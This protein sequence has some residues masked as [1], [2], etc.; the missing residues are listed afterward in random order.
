MCYKNGIGTSPNERKAIEYLQKA[1]NND[2]KCQNENEIDPNVDSFLKEIMLKNALPWIPF[3]EL[4]NIQNAYTDVAIIVCSAE[5]TYPHKSGVRIRK[6]RLDL[7]TGFADADSHEILLNELN[8]YCI[9]GSKRPTFLQ[10]YGVSRDV[11]TGHYIVVIQDGLVNSLERNLTSVVKMGWNDKLNLLLYIAR[12]LQLIH[13]CNIINCGLYEKAILQ[14]NLTSAYIALSSLLLSVDKAL[15]TKSKLIGSIFYI[16]PE[17]LNHGLFTKASDI[18]SFGIIMWEISSGKSIFDYYREYYEHGIESIQFNFDVC[19]GMRPNI[20]ENMVQSYSD[21]M[22][23][24]WDNDPQKR[25]SISKI[26]KILTNWKNNMAKFYEFESVIYDEPDK[27]E[28]KLYDSESYDIMDIDQDYELSSFNQQNSVN[29][30]SITSSMDSNIQ[31]E[32]STP[33]EWLEKAISEDHINYIEY[34]KFT[35]PVVIGIGGFGKVFK[36]EWKDGELT[37]A[38]KCLKVD[39]SIDEKIIK[40]FIDELKLLRKVSCHPNVIAFYGVTKDNSGNYNMILEYANEGTLREY[41][42]KR[43]LKLQWTDK[44]R[45]AKEIALG[46]LYLHDKNIIHRDLHSKNILVHQ[47]HPKI[48]D[49]GLSKQMNEVSTTSNSIV[50]GILAYI[51]PQCFISKDI[52]AIRDLTS[53][54]LDKS[55]GK[56]QAEDLHPHPL[57]LEI[58]TLLFTYFKEI[59]KSL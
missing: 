4:K 54:V 22:K 33:K 21:L 13:S 24:Y 37:V 42:K 26:L 49:L 57:N 12:D 41:L 51:E 36:C 1:R 15:T 44:L 5:W 55:F 25:P 38:L 2:D 19:N 3:N 32:E 47:R 29:L 17:V 28:Y 8:A 52:N 43:F 6:V 7:L 30:F 10:C 35:D 11:T 27:D 23:R 48:S 45:I 40:D 9:I 31:I 14:N 56:F 59:E 50:H 53:I 34:N 39:T 18:Y 58:Y 16:A 46:L 20:V